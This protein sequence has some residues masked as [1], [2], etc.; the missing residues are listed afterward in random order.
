MGQTIA[1]ALVPN[2]LDNV[3]VIQWNIG[4]SAYTCPSTYTTPQ[5][6]TLNFCIYIQSGPGVL[7]YT[8]LVNGSFYGTPAPNNA[9]YYITGV[10]GTRYFY[11][12][13]PGFPA[14]F[15]LQTATAVTSVQITGTAD[16]TIQTT[17]YPSLS[18]NGLALGLASAVVL[19]DTGVTTSTVTYA[20]MPVTELGMD[21]NTQDTAYF[22]YQ[23]AS[24]GPLP[25]G[26]AATTT[27]MTFY[28]TA[29]PD[30]TSSQKTKPY[31]NGWSS[32][33]SAILTVVGP[34][35]FPVPSGGSTTTS[36]AYIVVG[37]TGYRVFT[38]NT[39][40]SSTTAIS[41]INNGVGGGS[42]AL[43]D[44]ADFMLYTKA[45]YVDDAGITF[46]MAGYPQ[47]PNSNVPGDA[48]A[49]Q[50]PYVNVWSSGN[51]DVNNA[52]Y[53]TEAVLPDTV[54]NYLLLNLAPYSGG[55]VQQCSNS[56]FT[57]TSSGVQATS[58]SSSSSSSSNLSGGD[59]A[60]IVI[61]TVAGVVLLLI[62]TVCLM[63]T[64]MSR[65][66]A[67]EK[68][69]AHNSYGTYQKSTNEPS[70]VQLE[71]SKTASTATTNV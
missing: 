52:P 54:N 25:C 15:A 50:L 27:Q 24:N 56:A 3:A 13:T 48:A 66:G 18:T 20:Q 45:P 70:Q 29:V 31:A 58:T 55:S 16:N 37:A 34:V 36:T 41:P 10:Q 22:A 44:G 62:L 28:Y 9:G 68:T 23:L 61:G 57:L 39:G 1:E 30:P 49:L 19:P 2:Y 8:V 35:A 17:G 26:P 11:T 43:Y 7:A 47:W 64:F 69:P 40:V 67:D 46:E 59:I 12:G 65:R 38:D 53:A 32:C 60:G 42:S 4:G 14:T 33:M 51:T 21:Y 71:E 6:A 63:L 5:L